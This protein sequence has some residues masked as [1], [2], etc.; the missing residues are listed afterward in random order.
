MP[1]F[2][3]LHFASYHLPYLGQLAQGLGFRVAELTRARDAL[4]RSFSLAGSAFAA[5]CSS[6]HFG[7]NCS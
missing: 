6:A 1:A 2:R 3:V 5:L 7:S 4:L